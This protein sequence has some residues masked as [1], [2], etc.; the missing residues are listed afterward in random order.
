MGK[1]PPELRTNSGACCERSAA[2]FSR[3]ARAW[4]QGSARR[5]WAGA[6]GVGAGVE[7][8]RAGALG[9]A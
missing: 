5:G 9:A 3:K 7:A 8:L 2:T 4:H 6:A 1:S